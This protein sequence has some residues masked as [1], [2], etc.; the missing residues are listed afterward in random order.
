MSDT[1]VNM[2]DE[3]KKSLDVTKASFTQGTGLVNYNLEAPAKML[4]PVLT[5]LR[6][7][8]PRV[9]TQGGTQSNWKAITS[10]DSANIGFGV[11][12][13]K[14]GGLLSPTVQNYA[15][16]FS[17]CGLESSFTWEAEYAAVGFDDVRS[18]NAENLL[19]QF[20]IKE[21]QCILG[22]LGTFGLGV[23][24]TPA[25]PTFATT[26]G[27]IAAG[28]YFVFVSSLS[29]EGFLSSSVAAG[30]PGQVTRTNAD[31][32]T[33]VYGGGNSQISVASASVTSTGATSTISTTCAAV[34]G[35]VAYAWY[36]GT[37]A[38]TAGLAAITTV[39]AVTF[40]T[41]P[42]GAQKAN[43]AKLA[44]DFSANALVFD[45]LLSQAYKSGSQS[46]IKSLNGATLTSDGAG[47]IVEID[48]ALK[49][50]WDNYRLSPTVIFVNST[51]AQTITKKVIANGG[52]PLVRLAGD[53]SGPVSI[54]GGAVV[55]SYLN[56]FAMG[57]GQLIPILIH[58]FVPAGT[59]LMVTEELPYPVDNIPNLFQM[60]LRREYFLT[61]WP[62]TS[63]LQA[64]GVYTDGVLQCYFPASMAVICNVLAG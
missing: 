35:A 48:A 20:M 21:E 44:A 22:G 33:S 4:V 43:D 18:R 24:P 29:L 19:K 34:A 41:A 27:T 9:V 14:R 59:I 15:A 63:R 50:R 13:G 17:Y 26:G 12:E 39:N 36:F 7:R 31:A 47:G 32:S 58:P 3:L 28:T 40:A 56:K 10:F 23:A 6:N 38:A 64:T 52:A 2:T 16:G 37:S 55:G 1:N 30:L 45:G 54:A 11:E 51:E 62:V 46:Y 53:G 5:P 25:T 42:A 60:K 49:D 61:E 8:I 57:T